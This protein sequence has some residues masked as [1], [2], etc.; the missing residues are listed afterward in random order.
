MAIPRYHH[1]AIV[2][3]FHDFLFVVGG[4]FHEEG[5][6]EEPIMLN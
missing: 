5:S 6:Q 1:T 4:M 3:K 2:D